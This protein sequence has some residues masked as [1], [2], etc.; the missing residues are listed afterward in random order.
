[1][2]WKWRRY[3]SLSSS[4]FPLHPPGRMQL[5]RTKRVIIPQSLL[6]I[7]ILPLS[8]VNSRTFPTKSQ[9]KDQGNFLKFKFDEINERKINWIHQ[10]GPSWKETHRKDALKCNLELIHWTCGLGEW[11]TSSWDLCQP[12]KFFQSVTNEWMT[13]TVGLQRRTLTCISPNTTV[14]AARSVLITYFHLVWFVFRT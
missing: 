7:K 10:P 3:P 8:P 13:P 1:M 14:L 12:E 6:I 9:S 2:L 4:S 5:C 11:H